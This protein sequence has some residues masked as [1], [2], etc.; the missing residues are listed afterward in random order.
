MD[1]LQ[2]HARTCQSAQETGFI[3]PAAPA[4]AKVFVALLRRRRRAFRCTK[5]LLG[6]GQVTTAVA[7]RTNRDPYGPRDIGV[8]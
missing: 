8:V 1:T 5:L 2:L 3:S 4:A 6:G 7:F